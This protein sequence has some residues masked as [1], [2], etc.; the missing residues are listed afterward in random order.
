MPRLSSYL[1]TAAKNCRAE[2]SEIFQAQSGIAPNCFCKSRAAVNAVNEDSLSDFSSA[3]DEMVVAK[4]NF[5]PLKKLFRRFM[6][7]ML[8]TE[9]NAKSGM[10]GF[11][12]QTVTHSC[13]VAM[14]KPFEAG[15]GAFCRMPERTLKVGRILLPQ[16]FSHVYS[17]L[18][19]VH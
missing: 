2:L 11:I 3:G 16:G 12:F 18:H 9:P 10:A 4:I 7:R 6:V 1:K 8:N 5:K 17:T 14:G 15:A 13:P 19:F